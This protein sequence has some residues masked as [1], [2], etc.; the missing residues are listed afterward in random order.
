MAESIAFLAQLHQQLG[1]QK[2]DL[3]VYPDLSKPFARLAVKEGK[4]L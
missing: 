4:L 3:T 1:E 2:I